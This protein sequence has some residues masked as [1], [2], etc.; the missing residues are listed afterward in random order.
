MTAL[1]SR[2]PG[3]GRIVT[4]FVVTMVVAHIDW[5]GQRD[6]YRN[7]VIAPASQGALLAQKGDLEGAAR[8]FR[9]GLE[10]TPDDPWL[11]SN[12]GLL[13]VTAGDPGSAVPLLEESLRIHPD[14]IEA[15]NNLAL[16]W[17]EA[18]D[19]ANAERVLALGLERF[20]DSKPLLAMRDRVRSTQRP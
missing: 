12:L 8:L 9:L 19:P 10:R 4:L 20:P 17:L 7:F 5:L 3:R 18:G 15:W 11:L 14:G 16:A 2:A 13:Y 6:R 1:R